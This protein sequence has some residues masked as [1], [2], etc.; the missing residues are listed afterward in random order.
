VSYKIRGR[1]L[2]G[3]CVAV[4]ALL[5]LPA[6]AA[7]GVT[8]AEPRCVGLECGSPVSLEYV[9]EAHGAVRAVAGL[10]E[11][12]AQTESGFY[13]VPA[14]IFQGDVQ[15]RIVVYLSKP[16]EFGRMPA[17]VRNLRVVRD[18]ELSLGSGMNTATLM[19]IDR[20]LMRII[21]DDLG[22][23][24]RRPKARAA[25]PWNG[26]NDFYHCNYDHVDFNGVIDPWYGPR[27]YG[28][29]WWNLSGTF[30]NWANSMTNHRDGDT[31]MATGY[32]GNGGRYCARQQSVDSTFS[33]NAPFD[34]NAASSIAL[35]GSSPDRC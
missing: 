32:G 14:P 30:D 26:C 10:D 33:N 34:N 15:P 35:L 21:P 29:G 20:G 22:A 27:F 8:S 4:A 31:L 28:T 12:K 2:L 23:A 1:V 11:L 7:A 25:H 19:V 16:G 13:E 3:M 5:A 24:Q 9:P 6:V 18:Y 17:S